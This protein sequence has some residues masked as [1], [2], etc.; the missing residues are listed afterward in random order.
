MTHLAP[1][2]A[3]GCTGGSSQ[4]KSFP[5]PQGW[6][7][8]AAAP[9]SCSSG[10]QADPGG[11][12]GQSPFCPWASVSPALAASSARSALPFLQPSS[13]LPLTLLKL[14][15]TPARAFPE[16][17]S[18]QFLRAGNLLIHLSLVSS[19]VRLW[20]SS[21]DWKAAPDGRV[22]PSSTSTENCLCTPMN[23]LRWLSAC[24]VPHVRIILPTSSSDRE[25]PTRQPYFSVSR[26]S[27]LG[28]LPERDPRPVAPES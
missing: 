12:A 7:A 10:K 20:A 26:E 8:A 16:I 24:S 23:S 3:S 19:G 2:S 15:Q 6:K 18:L 1:K 9:G 21:Q 13:F 11:G 14:L 27:P 28:I 22:F 4:P 5:E 25:L 17:R